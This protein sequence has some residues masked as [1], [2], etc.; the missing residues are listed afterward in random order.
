MRDWG[1]LGMG[2]SELHE[3]ELGDLCI[4]VG[5]GVTPRGGENVYIEDGVSLIRS[6]NIHDYSFDYNGLV[7]INDEQAKKMRNVEI[8]LL[9]VVLFPRQYYQLGLASMYL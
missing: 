9:V 2:C 4:K 5:S 3:S 7:F 6:Q 1:L 8:Q